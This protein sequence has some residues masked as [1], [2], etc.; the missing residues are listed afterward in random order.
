MLRGAGYYSHALEIARSANEPF[1]YLDILLEDQGDYDEGIKYVF[2]LP[3]EKAAEAMNRYG[4]VLV[5][6]RPRDSTGCLMKLCVPEQS[7]IEG[8]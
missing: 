3:R 2:Q 1:W 7:K 5:T 4:K 6:H 8:K